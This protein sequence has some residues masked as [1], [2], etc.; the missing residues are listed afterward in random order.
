M[1]FFTNPH[2]TQAINQER[3]RQLRAEAEEHRRWKT[4]LQRPVETSQPLRP[5]AKV[6]ATR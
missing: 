3:I 6:R 2:M 1:E 4:A 5:A